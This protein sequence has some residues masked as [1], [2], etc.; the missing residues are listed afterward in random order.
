MFNITLLILTVEWLHVC[1][2]A[3]RLQQPPSSQGLTQPTYVTH[4]IPLCPVFL[5]KRDSFL[6]PGRRE[7]Q[8][9]PLPLMRN[10]TLNL[11]LFWP[12]LFSCCFAVTLVAVVLGS[13]CF[14]MFMSYFKAGSKSQTCVACGRVCVHG[15]NRRH[16]QLTTAAY[17]VH[18]YRA[19]VGPHG[20]L[21]KEVTGC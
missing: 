4:A 6:L 13:V 1:V 19:P 7:G 16:C 5:L 11:L 9:T 12:E 10:V 2:E 8:G 20:A 14:E 3:G 15:G 17:G 18:P 21:K